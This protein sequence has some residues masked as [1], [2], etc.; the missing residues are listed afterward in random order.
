MIRVSC[1][2]AVVLRKQVDSG[3]TDEV[4]DAIKARMHAAALQVALD[5]RR[6]GYVVDLE[7][8]YLVAHGEEKE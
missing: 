8:G 3:T 5:M 6:D 2:A 7:V 1:R 4:I